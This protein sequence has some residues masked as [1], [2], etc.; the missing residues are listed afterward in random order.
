MM[1]DHK[2]AK[3]DYFV[4]L[5]AL[6]AWHLEHLMPSQGGWYTGFRSMVEG[7]MTSG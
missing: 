5:R 3:E 4:A 2:I 1:W 7:E 6:N